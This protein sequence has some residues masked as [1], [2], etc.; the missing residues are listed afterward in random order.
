MDPRAENRLTFLGTGTSQ[1]VPLIGCHCP[2]CRSDDPRDKRL[3]TSALITLHGDNFLIDAGPDFRQQML[4]HHVEN[5]RAILLTHEHVDHIFGLDDI[6]A[7]NWIQK[8]PADIYAER[9]VHTAIRRIFHYVFARWRY[10]GIPQMELHDVS[11]LPFRIGNAEFTPIRCFHHKLPVLGFRTGDLTYLTDVNAIPEKEMKK[12]RG[13]RMLVVNALRH[14]KH[15][16]H[17]NLEEALRLIEEISPRYSYLTHLSH[18]LGKHLDV[19]K[20][21]PGN[22]FL[23]YDGL[24]VTL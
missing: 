10:P 6:R 17:F 13:T 14:E 18:S 3:R 22:V 1:G 15:I 4:T 8:R 9:R 19:E 16:S 23:A 21:L 24:S 2:V 5:L 12:I 11:D 7:F 20:T